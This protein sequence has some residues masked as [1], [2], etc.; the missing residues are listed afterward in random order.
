MP[1]LNDAL[2]LATV[3]RVWALSD[4]AAELCIRYLVL[5][6]ELFSSGDINELIAQNDF[7]ERLGLHL[8]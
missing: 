1:S 7:A 4:Y 8:G 6:T 2:F 3:A 5:L